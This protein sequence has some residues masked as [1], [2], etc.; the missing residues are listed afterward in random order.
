MAFSAYE[1]ILMIFVIGAHSGLGHNYMQSASP[2]LPPISIAASYENFTRLSA[3]NNASALQQQLVAL[4]S[5][6]SSAPARL[7][8]G[9]NKSD[10]LD[11][12]ALKDKGR[13]S[14]VADDASQHLSSRYQADLTLLSSLPRA[15]QSCNVVELEQQTVFFLRTKN[16]LQIFLICDALVAEQE[17]SLLQAMVAV[18]ANLYSQLQYGLTDGLTG[19]LNRQA[20]DEQMASLY[21]RCHSRKLKRRSGDKSEKPNCCFAFIDVDRFK[22]VN[23]CYGHLSGDQVLVMIAQ[24][25]RQFFREEDMVFRY[26]GEEFV[27]ILMDSDLECS[28]KVLE[29]F[30]K[31]IEKQSLPNIGRVSISIGYTCLKMD[32]PVNEVARQ[33][34]AALYYVKEN[35]RNAVACYDTLLE[36]EVIKSPSD[37]NSII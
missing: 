37:M 23:D 29:R 14:K 2:V 5:K 4:V 20:Y 34:D 13:N 6:L 18:Y 10:A 11:M 9:G 21:A 15:I 35:G 33:A 1:D 3:C 8:Q 12:V 24:I 16:A 30:R 28:F 27:V 17:R 26:G 19:L 7:Y 31:T 36:S 25:T 32:V 22:N